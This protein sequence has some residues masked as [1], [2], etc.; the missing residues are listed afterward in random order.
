[1]IIV[2]IV[3]FTVIALF[4]SHNS[5]LF[6]TQ[7]FISHVMYEDAVFHALTEQECQMTNSRSL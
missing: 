5:P 7:C 3:F 4:S 6:V 2:I 1:V